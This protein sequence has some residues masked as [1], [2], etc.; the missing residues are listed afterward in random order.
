MIAHLFK[1]IWNRKKQN[2]L[3]MLEM[4]ISFIV[5]FAVFTLLVY[6]YK[7]YNLPK[8]FDYDH[9]W[10]IKYNDPQGMQDADSIASFNASVKRM[11][12]SLP[13]VQAVSFSSINVPFGDANMGTSVISNKITEQTEVYRVD[14]D[15]KK[16]LNIN[17]TE[18]RWFSKEDDISKE[19]AVVINE[20][21][22]QRFFGA[23]NAV[24]KLINYEG[25]PNPGNM[26]I[27]GVIPELKDKGDFSAPGNGFYVR[28]DTSNQGRDG[29]LLIKVRPGTGA[30]FESRLYKALAN[31]I[32][33]TSID[34]LH[35]DQQRIYKNRQMLGPII[36][37]MVFAGF[38]II[39]VA[40]GLF[41]ILW[42]N[43]NKRRSEIGLRRA[44]GASGHAISLQLIA[45]ALV[46]STMSLLVGSFF[47]VQFPL[48]NIFN[49]ASGV[50]LSA[51]LLAVLFIYSLV[52]V[53]AFYPGRQ[54]AGI[55]PAVALH[56]D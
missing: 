20:A 39:N 41:G 40:L 42:Y 2:F 7:N 1:L 15:Y 19:K 37:L 36:I 5:M 38:L 29:A 24:G 30:A 51:L 8:G 53:C 45:E 6:Y 48:L 43:I 46:L 50:Y 35:M 32:R 55:Y 52:I 4:L 18:G 33:S 44:V 12:Q 9:V 31:I 10:S 13:E 34:I 22:K 54:A 11:I 3:L 23:E 17:L 26:R 16:T 14:D 25:A 49:I 27:V 28:I 56:E 21:L 47:A